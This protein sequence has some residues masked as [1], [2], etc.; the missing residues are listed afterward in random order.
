[1]HISAIST[2]DLSKNIELKPFTDNQ[3]AKLSFKNNSKHFIG[4]QFCARHAGNPKIWQNRLFS[5]T[6]PGQAS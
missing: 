5:Y 3:L 2:A 1:M 4:I 6:Q